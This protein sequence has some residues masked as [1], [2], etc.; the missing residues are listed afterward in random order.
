LAGF[1]DVEEVG[2]DLH[3]LTILLPEAR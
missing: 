1:D 3:C 2:F